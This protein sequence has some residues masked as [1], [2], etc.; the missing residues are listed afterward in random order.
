MDQIAAIGAVTLEREAAIKQARAADDAL[1]AAQQARVTNL[2]V[3][4]NAESTLAALQKQAADEKA[5]K[6]VDELIAAIGDVTLEKEAQIAAARDAYNALTSDQKRLVESLAVL[7]A[8]EAQLSVLKNDFLF[9]DGATGITLRADSGVL[10]LDTI[11][12][13]QEIVSGDE[14]DAILAKEYT[15][16]HL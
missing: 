11:K 13:V 4:T 6:A 7:T 3:L 14:Y 10:P 8:A 9:E 5:A 12:P 15:A 16:F 2:T 1:T